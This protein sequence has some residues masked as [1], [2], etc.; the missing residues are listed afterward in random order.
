MRLTLLLHFF[1][2]T[3]YF[4]LEYNQLTMSWKFQ[5]DS[6]EAQLYTYTYPFSPKLP[7]TQV[8]T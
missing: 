8:A 3:F 5:V 7:L 1:K 6:K 2:K 4:I